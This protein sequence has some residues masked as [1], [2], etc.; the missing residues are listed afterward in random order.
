ML[1]A[2][3]WNRFFGHEIPGYPAKMYV[4]PGFR[5]TYQSFAP[6]PLHVEDPTPEDPDPKVGF[7]GGLGGWRLGFGHPWTND[8]QNAKLVTPVGQ[9]S[10]PLV[11]T[12][13]PWQP[14]ERAWTNALP[15]EQAMWISL[16]ICMGQS[17]S[18][19]RDDLHWSIVCYSLRI[20]F[21]DAAKRLPRAF[22]PRPYL[23][24]AMA[25]GG[26][27][28]AIFASFVVSTRA[29]AEHEDYERDTWLCNSAPTLGG[30]YMSHVPNIHCRIWAMGPLLPD[31]H[32]P[33]K[34]PKHSQPGR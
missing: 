29:L 7:V 9:S 25:M 34:I 11:H 8:N 17:L 31:F 2:K 10:M 24:E 18:S 4:F 26:M 23:W 27:Q 6:P 20:D 21:C 14:R 12:A 1:G 22:L 19:R 30:P 15:S 3:H 16:G 32:C 28:F 13:V 33:R 5:G